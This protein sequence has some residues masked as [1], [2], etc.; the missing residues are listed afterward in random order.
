MMGQESRAIV[1]ICG[2]AGAGKSTVCR[3]LKGHFSDAVFE[4]QLPRY[5]RWTMGAWEALRL[6]PLCVRL[7]FDGL[8][9]P[10]LGFPGMFT[11]RIRILASLRVL[12][13][14]IQSQ[15]HRTTGRI[16][17][18]QG[19]IFCQAFL[20][21]V[22]SSF[23]PR[24]CLRSWIGRNVRDW[25]NILKGIIWLDA[26]DGTLV[27]RVC[28]RDQKHSLK[29]RS[30]TERQEFFEGYRSAY[31]G[32]ISMYEQAGI[33]VLRISTEE[34]PVD[35][36][37]DKIAL[38]LSRLGSRCAPRASDWGAGKLPIPTDARGRS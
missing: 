29:R 26:K 10:D 37:V 31:N 17:F 19:P 32:L 1:E 14:T 28:R 23:Q 13:R 15:E 18:D 9:Y 11:Y 33:P 20:L 35:V 4:L 34:D 25:T 16:I 12:H 24:D 21:T 2:V 38:F 22:G 3:Q 30:D 27:E 7:G 5:Q 36:T 8:F 6:C